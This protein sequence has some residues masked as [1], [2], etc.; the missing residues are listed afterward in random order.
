M[1][2]TITFCQ[3]CLKLIYTDYLYTLYC[4]MLNQMIITEYDLLH[5][6]QVMYPQS[7]LP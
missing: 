4:S 5:P 2:D 3:F 1:Q 7:H 6:S